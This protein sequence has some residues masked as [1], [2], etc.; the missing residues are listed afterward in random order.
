MRQYFDETERTLSA[1]AFADQALYRL[2]LERVFARSWLFLAH[3]SQI[4]EPGDFFRTFMGQDQVLVVRQKDGSVAAFLNQCRHRGARL[5][6]ADDGA[7]RAF[8]CPYHGW[9]YGLDGTLMSVTHEEVAYPAGVDKAQW[10]AVRVPR[11]EIFH[12]LIFGCWDAK[13]P[14]FRD[15]LGEFLPYMEANFARAEATEVLDGVH[16]WRIQTNWKLPA[17]QFVSD[18]YHFGVTHASAVMAH[19]PEGMGPPPGGGLAGR[20]AR[21]AMGHGGGFGGDTAFSDGFSMMTLGPIATQHLTGTHREEAVSR[22]GEYLGRQLLGIHM[23]VF[24]N[25][26]YLPTNQTLRVWHPKGPSEIEVWTAMLRP[27]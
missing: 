4:P 1:A 27:R 12:G 14:S 11:V 13:V 10:S 26:S 20:Q 8:T 9:T 17:E 23:T 22:L 19:L 2:E 3:E 6:R 5:C 16:K 7:A 18:I 15:H 25:M 24:P 21:S